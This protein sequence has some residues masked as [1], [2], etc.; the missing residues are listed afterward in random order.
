[1]KIKELLGY[2]T[3][4]RS[5]F[6]GLKLKF[7]FGD[8]TYGTPYNIRKFGIYCCSLGYSIKYPD[9]FF[10]YD[11][12]PRLTINLFKKQLV[13][14]VVPNTT[15]NC[16]REYWDAWW[17]YRNKTNK[18]ESVPFRLNQLFDNLSLTWIKLSGKNEREI[19]T[20]YYPYILKDKYVFPYL[21]LDRVKEIE[22]LI[23]N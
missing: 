18:K 9:D 16:E 19:K 20:D 12:P 6:K 8:L 3:V 23:N 22:S 2:L 5:P 7:Y 10:R 21:M 1:M 4:L 11:Y 13:I 17:N 15:I 14:E